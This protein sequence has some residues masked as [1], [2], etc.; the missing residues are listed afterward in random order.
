MKGR[1]HAQCVESDFGPYVRPILRYTRILR[2]FSI[3]HRC[4]GEWKLRYV[5]CSCHPKMNLSFSTWLLPNP[6][7]FRK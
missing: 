5:V 7:Y 1:A 6:I 4:S 3:L 2:C